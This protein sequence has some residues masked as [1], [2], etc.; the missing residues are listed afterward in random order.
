MCVSYPVELAHLN[1]TG[2]FR[3]QAGRDEPQRTFMSWEYMR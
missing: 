3:P 2:G 1:Q